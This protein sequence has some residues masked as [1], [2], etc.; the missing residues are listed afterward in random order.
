MFFSEGLHRLPQITIA[1]GLVFLM[2]VVGS[3]IKVLEEV[4]DAG[5]RVEI[6]CGIAIA[7]IVLFS[8]YLYGKI[9]KN[10]HVT[11][12]MKIVCLVCAFLLAFIAVEVNIDGVRYEDT[13]VT[14][15]AGQKNG[16]SKN[17]EMWLCGWTE[18]GEVKSVD[19]LDVQSITNIEYRADSKTYLYHNVDR[20]GKGELILRFDGSVPNGLIFVKHAWSGMIE[21][22]TNVGTKETIDLYDEERGNAVYT[23]PRGGLMPVWKSALFSAADALVMV[24]FFG[25]L[26][27]FLLVVAGLIKRSFFQK[28]KLD[29]NGDNKRQA[30]YLGISATALPIAYLSYLYAQNVSE[31]QLTF[32]LWIAV[33]L[34]C[35]TAATYILLYTA[36]YSIIIA[37]AGCLLVAV[38]LFST[39]YIRDA[40]AKKIVSENPLLI[41]LLLTAGAC[42]IVFMALLALIKNKNGY[43]IVF[44]T[45]I[46]IL[47]G[48][49]II[50]NVPS[51][52]Q[53]YI[54]QAG[55]DGSKYIKTDYIVDPGL[56]SDA[57]VYWLHC[58]GMIGFLTYEK[59]FGDL[60]WFRQELKNRGFEINEQATFE[61]G[62]LTASCVPTLL[63]PDFYDNFFPAILTEKDIHAAVSRP[64]EQKILSVMREN[65][66]LVSA[67]RKAGYITAVSGWPE[68]ER[69][70]GDTDEQ[71]FIVEGNLIKTV[72][73]KKEGGAFTSVHVREFQD[74]LDAL[75][76][77][78]TYIFEGIGE[79]VEE[80]VVR[81]RISKDVDVSKGYSAPVVAVQSVTCIDDQP[82]LTI[83][84]FGEAHYPFDYNE[85]GEKITDGNMDV[86]AYAEQY[87]Y[88]TKVVLAAV[89]EIM[90]RDRNAVIILQGDHG[91]HGNTE[92]DFIKAFEESV[93]ANE[94][95]NQVLSAIR[96]PEQYKNGEEVYA[97]TNPLN[98]SRFLIN[99]FVG[100]NYEYLPA[101]TPIQ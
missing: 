44:V 100:R 64:E 24:P 11:K 3:V 76:G 74:F 10:L 94:L 8:V 33:A 7:I 40:L 96:I 36:F 31:I 72:T 9:M 68:W 28:N 82:R 88:A 14:I 61:G 65:S 38:V 30:I 71:Y 13:I 22:E 35:I 12:Q 54:R 50:F 90:T 48:M 1:E 57:N 66:E 69:Y 17:S 60:D 43:N 32:I 92:E 56:K 18:D 93:N 97:Y 25:L 59:Y 21:I 84:P 77:P 75:L 41:A 34:L 16:L 20:S 87:R 67:F 78:M 58:D 5:L 80:T 91:L 42:T 101:N 52:V 2:S 26:I 86:L 46:E 49:M 19:E 6:C 53:V 95:W 51:A 29:K 55:T 45:A 4:S 81:E 39:S 47:T 15:T 27:A 23:V 62:H 99:R 70:Y 85:F 63:C 98:I 79:I 73:N 89:D 83:Y 37:Y